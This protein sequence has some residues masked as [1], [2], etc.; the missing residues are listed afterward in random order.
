MVKDHHERIIPVKKRKTQF[1]LKSQIQNH[2]CNIM[3][4]V[5]EKKHTVP[6]IIVDKVR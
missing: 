1:V 4:I 5:K 3:I 6:S 2:N